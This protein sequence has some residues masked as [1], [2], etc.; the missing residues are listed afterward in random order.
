MIMNLTLDQLGLI[1][2][3]LNTEKEMTKTHMKNAHVDELAELRSHIN[4]I[5]AL[6]SYFENF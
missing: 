3:S 2:V 1:E 5:E 4:Q 6:E